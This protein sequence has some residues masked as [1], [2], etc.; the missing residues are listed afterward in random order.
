MQMD[1]IINNKSKG[2]L[3]SIFR[4]A[5]IAGLVFTILF[6]QL[7]KI[8]ISFRSQSDL[9]DSSIIFFPKHFSIASFIEAGTNMEYFTSL[10]K[11][12]FL[13]TI[14]A[15]LHVFSCTLTAYSIA[16]FEYRFKSIVYG[17][18]I[19]TFLVPPSLI[20]LP[21]YTSFQ[22]F[23]IL[24]IF[25]LIT[26]APVSVLDNPVTLFM[27]YATANCLKSGLFIFL[28]V[29]FF[30]NMPRVLDEAAEVDGATNLQILTTI[31]LPAARTMLVTVFLF[32][33]VW[34]WTDTYYTSM[35]FRS[36]GVMSTVLSEAVKNDLQKTF[37]ESSQLVSAASVLFIIPLVILYLICNKAFVQSIENS[38]IVG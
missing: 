24:G 30:K 1:K 26:G 15:L 17:C 11:T 35:F 32:T 13:C 36:F 2:L 8:I 29:Q 19:L 37:I 23:D 18:V 33:F 12:I 7:N 16:K 22:N 20:T 27:L 31:A 3:M 38:G 9:I 4:Y 25:K 14:S 5:F 34:Q 21:L 6:P 28:L 10:F